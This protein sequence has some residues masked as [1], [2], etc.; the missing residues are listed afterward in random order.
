MR[1]TEQVQPNKAAH[2]AGPQPGF[3]GNALHRCAGV[4]T[5]LAELDPCTDQ[6]QQM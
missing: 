3:V 2:A 1:V 6:L 5:A 4:H